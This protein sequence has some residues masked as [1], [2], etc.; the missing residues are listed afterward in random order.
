MRTSLRAGLKEAMR[1]RDRVATA[2]L[3]SVIAAIE[4][5]EAVDV[6]DTPVREASDP[7]VAG[8]SA[9]VGAAEAA[10]R[11]L[12]EAD[13]AA[14]VRAAI[15]ERRSSAAEYARLGRDDHADRLRAEA[16]VLARYLP[17]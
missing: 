4:N 3:R 6:T 1:A 14:V 15:S 2:A 11:V 5:A 16:D 7:H 10:R 13:E 8:T 12:S 9:G 17:D